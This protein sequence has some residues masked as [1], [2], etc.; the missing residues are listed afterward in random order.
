MTSTKPSLKYYHRFQ[1]FI[2][3]PL[4]RLYL[5][6]A[7]A[8]GLKDLKPIK[9]PLPLENRQPSVLLCGVGSIVTAEEFIRF[10]LNQAPQAKITIIDLRAEQIEQIT[11]LAQQKFPRSHITTYSINALALPTVI[12]P[13]SLDWIETDALFEF[14][15]P[16]E[17]KKL[18]QI[19][20]QLLK[21]IGFATTRVIASNTLTDWLLLK[22]APRWLH[23][24][25][26]RHKTS[27]LETLFHSNHFHFF[28]GKT[29]I[30]YLRRY[31]LVPK[32]SPRG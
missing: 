19:W 17:L 27:E 2:S 6:W 12:K 28:S 29:P 16:D 14:L 26:Y 20:R 5:R 11:R 32:P 7:Y 18:I 3:N 4:W 30:P 22:F 15:T 25:F 9:H 23:F 21:P 8:Q 10:A 1:P 24:N 31:T 13:A